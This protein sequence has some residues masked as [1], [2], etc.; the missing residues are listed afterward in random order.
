MDIPNEMIEANQKLLESMDDWIE[1]NCNT[2]PAVSLLELESERRDKL[3]K[4]LGK[5]FLETAM[6]ATQNDNYIMLSDD[7]VF[8]T[9]SK[10][11]LKVKGIWTQV[12]LMNLLDKNKI[13]DEEYG[14]FV[15]QLLQ[16]NYDYITINEKVVIRAIER[17]NW[18]PENNF[19]FVSKVL[20]ANKTSPVS[21]S[22]I[23]ANV[24]Y[25]IWKK[26]LL[27]EIKRN[28]IFTNLLN[29]FVQNYPK[30]QELINLLIS[31]IKIRF[32]LTP[33]WRDEILLLVSHWKK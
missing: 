26:T 20:N 27:N 22:E 13:T 10:N 14:G 23:L 21:A 18:N 16:M 2:E 25:E 28:S 3:N 11:D 9:L 4:I 32:A 33:I 7:Y 24:I 29:N 5:S 31:K 6:I 19:N 30:R 1:K 8:R 17:D 15:L 12:L